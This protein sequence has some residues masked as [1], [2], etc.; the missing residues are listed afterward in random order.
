MGVDRH[1]RAIAPDFRV[2][3]ATL[4]DR[5]RRPFL[6]VNLTDSPFGFDWYVGLAFAAL[7]FVVSYPGRLNEDSLYSVITATASA[8]PGNWHSPTLGWI[9]NLPGPLLGQPAG[10]LL[11]Q[12]LL[13]GAFAGFL[14]RLPATLRGRATIT[15]EILLRVA[16]VGAF[17]AIGKDVMALGVILVIIA[18]LRRAVTA[19]MRR[20]QIGVIAALFGLFLLIKAPNFLTIVVAAALLLP[21]FVGSARVYAGVLGSVLIVGM[22]AVPLNRWVDRTLFAAQDLHPDKQLIIFDLAAISLQTGENAFAAVPG[23]PT[24]TLPPIA[25]CFLPNMWDPFAPWGPC[26]GYSAAFDR[27]DGAL[28]R[29]WLRQIALHPVAYARHRLTYSGAV[30]L[31]QDHASWGV[32]GAAVNEADSPTA[33]RAQAEMM[34]RLHANRPVQAWHDR[35]ITAPFRSIERGLFKAPK[36]RAFALIGALAILLLCWIRRSE[37][38]RLG[39]LLPAGFAVGNFVMLLLFGVADPVRYMLPTIVLCYVAALALLAPGSLPSAPN[40]PHGRAV[41]HGGQSGE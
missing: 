25:G 24:K 2:R 9:W 7:C 19:P 4:T 36:V 10:A 23:W 27:V 14:P 33:R 1:K 12:S 8:S 5:W 39:A 32:S 35:A 41:K 31:S 34:H 22:M 20:W 37:G 3:V 6:D 38:L 28:T 21:L 30:L 15:G 11:V 26:R 29:Q 40:A 18:L 16:L 13:F 17:G